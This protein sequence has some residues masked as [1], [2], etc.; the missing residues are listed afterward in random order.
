MTE[1]QRLNGAVVAFAL[2]GRFPDDISELPPVSDTDLGPAIEAL[3]AAKEELEVASPRRSYWQ[4]ASFSQLL[5][6]HTH[7]KRRDERRR[8]LLDQECEGAAGGHC[9][10][11][12][13]RQ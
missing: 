3:G 10:V 13:H 9:P 12:N 1:P 5:G 6:R 11:E 7:D 4:V 2:D 8:Q